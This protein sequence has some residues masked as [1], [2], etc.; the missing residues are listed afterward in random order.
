ML[1]CDKRFGDFMAPII[2]NDRGWSRIGA[3]SGFTFK[4]ATEPTFEY[5]KNLESY[6]ESAPPEKN[7]NGQWT[8]YANVKA[9]RVS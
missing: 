9:R 7:D 8:Y 1:V 3:P 6:L 4:T 2:G 5:L